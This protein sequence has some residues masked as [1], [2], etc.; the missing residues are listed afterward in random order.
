MDIRLQW[1]QVKVAVEA[2]IERLI[3][4]FLIKVF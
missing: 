4:D 3:L 1:A 2:G